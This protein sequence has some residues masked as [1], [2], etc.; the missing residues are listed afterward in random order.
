MAPTGPPSGPVYRG[1]TEAEKLGKLDRVA[2]RC[3]DLASYL[4]DPYLPPG[5]E[6]AMRR[7][8]SRYCDGIT[9]A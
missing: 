8:I 9:P 5:I 3:R 7:L 2:R 4:D 1:L 6:D